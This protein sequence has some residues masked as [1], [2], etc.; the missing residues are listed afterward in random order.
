MGAEEEKQEDT[1]AG[2]FPSTGERVPPPASVYVAGGA[3][4]GIVLVSLIVE[5]F[6]AA[7]SAA[8]APQIVVGVFIVVD[9]FVGAWLVSAAERRRRCIY[10]WRSDA[11]E[12]IARYRQAAE[13][14]PKATPRALM[15][16]LSTSPERDELRQLA[17]ETREEALIA[18]AALRDAGAYTDASVVG[19]A[20]RA[21][22]LTTEDE[23]PPTA[24]SATASSPTSETA[25]EHGSD[26]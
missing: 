7:H 9:V 8:T 2:L 18:E 1:D 21:A 11:L 22:G 12:L 4:L 20:R 5:F 10:E 19:D 25:T 16:G 26:G 24:S 23:S 6:I 3:L 17:T 15:R 14:A 13:S